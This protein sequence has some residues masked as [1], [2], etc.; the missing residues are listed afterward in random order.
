LNPL[1]PP[2]CWNFFEDCTEEEKTQHLLRANANPIAS[3]NKCY[4]DGRVEKI[5]ENIETIGHNLKSHEHMNWDRL[6]KHILEIFNEEYKE[7]KK[8]LEDAN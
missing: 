5:L 4:E 6:K 8:S 1:R 3:G 7:Y 2:V